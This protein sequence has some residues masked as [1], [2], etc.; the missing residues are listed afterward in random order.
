MRKRS[1]VL[2]CILALSVA[3]N[4]QNAGKLNPTVTVTNRFAGE[5]ADFEMKTGQILIPDSLYRFDLN[6]DYTGFKI[7]YKGNDS[8]NPIHTELDMSERP[9]D[10]KRFAMTAAG[11]YGFPVLFDMN[12]VLKEKGRFKLGVYA[13]NDSFW[14][15][16][17]RI[18][19]YEGNVLRPDASTL[20]GFESRTKAGFDGR[21][22]WKRSSLL[23]DLKYDGIHSRMN[24]M[25]TSDMY[26]SATLSASYR[27]CNGGIFKMGV[28][29]SYTFGG[30]AAG[31][32]VSQLRLMENIYKADMYFIF[33]VAKVH[34]IDIEAAF[35]MTDAFGA[36]IKGAAFGGY[37]V[38]A[39]PMYYFSGNDRLYL[40]VGASMLYSGSVTN[41]DTGRPFTVFPRIK[42]RWKA[43]K[44]YLVV[45]SDA[46]LDGEVWGA[47]S[48]AKEN[49]FYVQDDTRTI[50]KHYK[51]D[52]G[53]RGNIAGKFHYDMYAGYFNVQGAPLCAVSMTGDAGG[54]LAYVIHEK[55]LR[56]INAGTSMWL[57]FASFRFTGDLLY[58]YFINA[59]EMTA[60][61]SWLEASADLKYQYRSRFWIHA[62]A[63]YKSDYKAG[64]YKVPYYVDLKAGMGYNFRKSFALFIE[65]A[66]L[67]NYSRQNVP[68][69]SRA[70]WEL[71]LGIKLL[72]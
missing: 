11:G 7:K 29:A 37:N 33:A 2:F 12:A 26:N 17:D 71:M 46:S 10:G 21:W 43:V 20:S 72:Y 14:G 5:I 39:S 44:D 23:L 18:L 67:L 6:F 19:P 59:E 57:D 49:L 52:V 51:T 55:N 65:G 25:G 68:L 30:Y 36:N 27:F 66:N 58:R 31:P 1:Y 32:S 42:F 41:V 47:G 16:F 64:D 50:V 53:L 63:A 38:L 56:S 60:L 9:Y 62:G 40:G 24:E 61:P 13:S 34:S 3:A 70:G 4:A 28:N 8:F 54:P 15:R 22:D 45:Y 69:Y 48:N 35:N